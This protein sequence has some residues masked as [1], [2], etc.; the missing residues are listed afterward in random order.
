MNYRVDFEYSIYGI[1]ANSESEARIKAKQIFENLLE[2]MELVEC[3]FNCKA[4]ED[5]TQYIRDYQR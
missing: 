2:S 3:N 4:T 5:S 1:E